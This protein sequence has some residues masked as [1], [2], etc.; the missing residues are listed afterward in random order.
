MHVFTFRYVRD[1]PKDL[2]DLVWTSREGKLVRSDVAAWDGHVSRTFNR[3]S[4]SD[5]EAVISDLHAPAVPSMRWHQFIDLAPVDRLTVNT[6]S[7]WFRA[8]VE[9]KKP[10]EISVIDKNGGKFLRVKIAGSDFEYTAVELDFAHDLVPQRL[11][12]QYEMGQTHAYSTTEVTEFARQ[13]DVWFP[14]RCLAKDG[15]RITPVQDIETQCLYEIKDLTFAKPAADALTVAFPPG[16]GIVDKL[17]K[18]AYRIR[19]DGRTE[20][21]PYLDSATGQLFLRG[22]PMNSTW[23][24]TPLSLQP[25]PPGPKA[26]PPGAAGTP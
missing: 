15:N 7:A 14:R 6:L 9:Q 24:P 13:G 4:K 23:A 18:R 5:L 2:I 11:E 12:W 25:K 8:A 17:S 20:E 26:S 10:I 3:N 22:R 19:V 16:T 21:T 1:A